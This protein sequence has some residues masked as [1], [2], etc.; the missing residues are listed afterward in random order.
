VLSLGLFV[1][2]V[3]AFAAIWGLMRILERFSAW[4]FVIYRAFIGVVLLIGFYAGVLA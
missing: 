4:P 2:S 3:S 1:A